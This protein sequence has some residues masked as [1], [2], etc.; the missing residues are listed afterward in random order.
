MVTLKE[1]AEKAGVSPITVSRVLNGSH[2]SKVSAKTRARVLKIAEELGYHPSIAARA[3]RGK[4]TY[5]FG[6]VV[7]GI[8]YSFVPG[9]IQ[10]LQDAAMDLHYSCLLYVTRWNAALELEIFRALIAKRVDGIVW[11]PEP[12]PPPDVAGLLKE[13][14]VV[15]L[16]HKEL[17]DK[18]ALLVDQEEGGYRATRHLIELGHRRIGNL[19]YHDRHGKLRLQGYTRALVEAGLGSSTDL[20]RR[21]GPTW[22]DALQG[23]HELLALDEPPTAIVCYSDL[24]AWAALRAAHQKG[25]RVPDQLSLVGFDDTPF[26]EHIEVPLT[27]VAQPKHELGR[28]AMAMLSDLIDGKRVESQV[29]SPTLVIRSSTARL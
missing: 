2:P 25:V 16:Q 3:L 26:V 4:R 23:A 9:I 29:L 15:Q 11:I 12:H 17:A 18:P 13:Q 28:L 22:E 24:V 27:T 10:G 7:P 20:V 1:I 21:V 19:A 14:K 8:D 6:L 5:Q